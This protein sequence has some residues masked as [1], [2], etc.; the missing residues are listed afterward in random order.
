MDKS[1]ILVSNLNA[2]SNDLY[3]TPVIPLNDVWMLKEFGACDVNL[4]DSKSSVYVLFFGSEVLKIISVTG[5]TCN[6]AI[7]QEI[8][9]NG[10]DTIKIRR[11]NNSGFTKQMPVWLKAFKRV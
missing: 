1:F 5:N 7:S 9:G 4:G 3:E 10:A 2:A 8:I 6:I 11:Y